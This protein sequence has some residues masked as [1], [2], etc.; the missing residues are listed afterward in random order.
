MA[1]VLVWGLIA[2]VIY[3]YA[4]YGLII[5]VWSRVL[6]RDVKSDSAHEP[7]VTL[8]IAAHNEEASIWD[9]LQNSLA[10]DY[11]REK[12]DIVVVSDGST[13]RTADR[14]REVPGITV[15]ELASNVGKAEALTRAMHDVDDGIVAFSDATGVWNNGALRALARN[16][17]DPSVGCVAGEVVYADERG[18][19]VENGQSLYWRYE[20]W[21]R[22]LLSRING[23]TVV[24]G[25]IHALRRELYEPSPSEVGLDMV[26][27]LRTL[28]RGYRVVYEPD[29]VSRELANQSV[30][31]EF[32]SRV[33]VVT[34]CY[35]EIQAL[36][37]FLNPIRYRSVAFHWFSHKIARWLVA[38]M[39]VAILVLSAALAGDAVYLTLFLAQAVFYG[40]G[41]AGMWF[42][43]RERTSKLMAV[44]FYFVLMNLTSLIGL[45]NYLRG[46][47][48]ASWE[49]IRG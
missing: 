18:T 36:S 31:A 41:A 2:A 26:V 46:R 38:P 10:L 21:H 32:R 24:S 13:D 16:F 44:P 45:I 27:P 11:P 33:R 30:A 15:I 8:L 7:R 48:V 1:E 49:P 6:G 34:R 35:R 20:V 19:G 43:G 47:R 17:A 3:V 22:R 12:L 39:L 29:A 5:A 40:I 37:R 23:L 25:S 14:A 28:A 4:G 42:A 9:K